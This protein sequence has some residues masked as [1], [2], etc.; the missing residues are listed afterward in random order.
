MTGSANERQMHTQVI[1]TLIPRWGFSIW[2]PNP[3][4]GRG[5]V[6]RCC[7]YNHTLWA[8]KQEWVFQS[9]DL[10]GYLWWWGPG[11]PR[12]RHTQTHTYALTEIHN[13]QRL[14]EFFTSQSQMPQFSHQYHCAEAANRYAHW[15]IVRGLQNHY[16]YVSQYVAGGSTFVKICEMRIQAW[17]VL[18][19]KHSWQSRGQISFL[20]L[21]PL[22][23][24]SNSLANAS[25]Q[26]RHCACPHWCT[27]GAHPLVWVHCR[28]STQLLLL[29]LCPRPHLHLI[30]RSKIPLH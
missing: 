28:C 21:F 22:T 30:Y 14:P 12:H 20:L 11:T 29:P 7:N 27:I 24:P 19:K 26:K 10:H 1:H 13:T 25:L 17:H 6:L 8:S 23:W 16:K 4:R 2:Q 5:G 18:R 9:G 15:S 3:R